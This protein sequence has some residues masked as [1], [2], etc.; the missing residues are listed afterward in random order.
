MTAI[1]PSLCFASKPTIFRFLASPIYP[2]TLGISRYRESVFANTTTIPQ[3][4]SLGLASSH[5]GCTRSIPVITPT[6]AYSVI[7]WT[8]SSSTPVARTPPLIQTTPTNTDNHNPPHSGWRQTIQFEPALI[9]S[10]T[11]YSIWPGADSVVVTLKSFTTPRSWR[12]SGLKIACNPHFSV[13]DIPIACQ[14]K[15]SASF[16]GL[17]P[18]ILKGRGVIQSLSTGS[19]CCLSWLSSLP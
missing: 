14:D 10:C 19:I 1:P 13:S 5:D 9:L 6:H 8:L 12:N 16:F 7:C 2:P 17:P 4:H 3:S 18:P 15:T 11:T